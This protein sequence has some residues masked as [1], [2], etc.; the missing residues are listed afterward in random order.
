MNLGDLG[1]QIGLLAGGLWAQ[2]YNERGAEK[3]YNQWAAWQNNNA[4][5][6]SLGL[7]PIDWKTYRGSQLKT[8]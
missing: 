1:Y 7:Q 6:A 3:G 5:R 2:N 4:Q 8:K